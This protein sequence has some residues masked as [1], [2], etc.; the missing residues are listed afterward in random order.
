MANGT[1]LQHIDVLIVGAGLSGIGMACHLTRECPTKTYAIVEARRDLGGTWDLFRYPGIRSDSDMYTLGYDFKPWTSDIAIAPGAMTMTQLDTLRHQIAAYA[2]LCEQRALLTQQIAEESKPGQ[3][4][5]QTLA[6][7]ANSLGVSGA[8]GAQPSYPG[9]VYSKGGDGPRGSRWSPNPTQLA[10]L[11]EL[12]ATGM[13]TPNGD[14]RTKITDE[15]TKLGPVN[16]ANVYNWFQNKKAR[17]KKAEREREAALAAG[18]P[19]PV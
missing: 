17:M 16:E 12:F 7:I 6:A 2:H 10:R 8:A 15:L 19:P 13:G 3:S 18:R 4:R 9:P 14:I 1:S 5:S 11:E